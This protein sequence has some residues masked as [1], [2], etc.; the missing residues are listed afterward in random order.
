MAAP[1]T[2][3]EKARTEMRVVNCIL[4][5]VEGIEKLF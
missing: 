2:V 1:K 4:M 5:F 3:A